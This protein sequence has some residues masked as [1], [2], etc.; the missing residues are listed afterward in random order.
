[1]LYQKIQEYNQE[2]YNCDEV[3]FYKRNPPQMDSD[4]EYLSEQIEEDI[5][6]LTIPEIENEYIYF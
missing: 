4:L 2:Y 5:F 1:M 3:N 6:Y